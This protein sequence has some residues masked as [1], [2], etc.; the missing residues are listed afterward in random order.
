MHVI[1]I[2][3]DG[4]LLANVK[5]DANSSQT[6]AVM[7]ENSV[8]VVFELSSNIKFKIGD[9]ATIFGELYKVAEAPVVT[10][11]SKFNFNY[12]L[13]LKA[14]GD[15]LSK[16][17]FL[18]LGSDNTLKESEFSVMGN[19]ATFMD[20]IR[21]NANR[22][23]VGWTIGQVI[24]TDYKNLTFSKDNCLS[25]LAKIADA[26]QTEWWIEG[27][28]IHLTK[29]SR[30]TGITFKQGRGKGLY[31]I[32]QQPTSGSSII[33]RLYPWG[34]DKNLPSE[35]G[36]QRLRLTVLGVYSV[37]NLTLVVTTALSGHSI[38]TF[39]WDAP[40]APGCTGIVV[41]WRLSGSTVAWQSATVPPTAGISVN[42]PAGIYDW[43]F[44]S[45]PF[46]VAS[47][48][49]TLGATHLTPMLTGFP[50][51]YIENNV[52]EYGVIE[53]TEVFDDIYPHRTGVVS[54]V[55][56][57]SE[58]L[59]TD[60]ALDFDVNAQLLPGLKPKVV[61]NTGQLSGYSFEVQSYNNTTKQFK[62]LKNAEETTL[63]IPSPTLRPGI[64]D[65]YVLVDMKMP[66]VYIT[67][68][69]NELLQKATDLLAKISQP[70]YTYNI[71]LDPVFIRSHNY[72]IKIGDEV[73]VTDSDL[74]INKKIRVINTVRNIV[75]EEQ[76]QLT[77]SDSVTQ[78]TISQINNNISVTQQGLSNLSN[79]VQNSAIFNGKVIGDLKF[80]QGTAVMPDMPSTPTTTGFEPVYREIATGKLFKKV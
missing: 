42:L 62:L 54:A 64:G 15:D 38:F 60:A 25:A 73:W 55:D 24:P 8:Q 80:E 68:A 44:T 36:S 2:F 18:F 45:Q 30:D 23:L 61:F 58:F 39:S 7:G 13:K 46:G 51:P 20:L 26:F 57:T 19:A 43:Q 28:T 11:S 53:F 63:D 47:D 21:Q 37:K 48:I 33:T 72:E 52:D 71:T 10:K 70:Q 74:Q 56:A 32:Q 14:E 50:Q 69:E 22:V 67:A 6:K 31:E 78:G 1:Q 16:V 5:P 35:Y 66:Q 40:T 3:R 27:T 4:A 41:Q 79:Q 76:Y 34:G 65:K 12:T 29:R 9:S 59:F 17:Q 77:L 49:V 75:N